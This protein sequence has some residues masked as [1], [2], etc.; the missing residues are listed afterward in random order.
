MSEAIF[1]AVHLQCLEETF[2]C[3]VC[4]KII[5]PPLKLTEIDQLTLF[6]S[7]QRAKVFARAVRKISG[8][9]KMSLKLGMVVYVSNPSSQEV[10][11][12]GLVSAKPTWLH[13]EFQV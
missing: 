9:F 11:T 6:S 5:L 1:F 13:S 10:E 12:W 7:L 2:G 4:V 8:S 3:C